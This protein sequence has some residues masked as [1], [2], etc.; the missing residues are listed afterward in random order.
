VLRSLPPHINPSG[1]AFDPEEDEPVLP[2]DW[3]HLQLVYE[4]L[5][6]FFD[7]AEFNAQVA[8]RYISPQFV[9][10]MLLLFDN[11]DPRERDLLKTTL[12]RIYGKFLHLRAFIRKSISNVFLEF[13]YEKERHLGISELLEILGSIINGFAV[14]LKEEHKIFLEKVLIPLHRP[15]SVSMY[16]SQLTYCINQF[17]LKDRELR[18]A[19]VLRLFKI[20][21]V[22]SSSKQV[23]FLSE[24]EELIEGMNQDQFDRIKFPLVNQLSFC[25]TSQQFQV[26]ER[27]LYFWSNFNFVGLVIPIL[28]DPLERFDSRSGDECSK[29]DGRW[30]S[31]WLP[32]V[33]RDVS[34]RIFTAEERHGRRTVDG[35]GGAQI[36]VGLV[37]GTN[38]GGRPG[39]RAEKSTEAVN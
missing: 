9:G 12:H 35:G 23:L 17:C 5:I 16:Y 20:W 22:L 14:P 33:Y 21:P 28:P 29:G 8:K 39:R 3:V 26:A 13:T 11:E 38:T 32:G 18:E 10:Q 19:I 25:I 15:R 1:P 34:K 6:R 36:L 37:G 2:P 30:G 7:L 27:A 24:V 31:E 4:L